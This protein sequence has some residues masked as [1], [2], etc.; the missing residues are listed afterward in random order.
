M[1]VLDFEIDDL[2]TCDIQYKY[3]HYKISKTSR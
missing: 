3:M 2:Q 1:Y